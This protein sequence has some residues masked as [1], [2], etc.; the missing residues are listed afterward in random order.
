[1][2]IGGNGIVLKAANAK[3]SHVAIKV[4][5][6]KSKEIQLLKQV[7][8]PSIVQIIHAERDCKY[9]YLITELIQNNTPLCPDLFSLCDGNPL[10]IATVK[11]I[12]VQ[13]ALG[14]NALHQSGWAHCDLKLENVLVDNTMQVKICDFGHAVQS[15]GSRIVSKCGTIEITPP[16]LLDPLYRSIGY[17]LDV[18]AL[19]IAIYSMIEGAPGAD[20]ASPLPFMLDLLHYPCQFTQLISPYLKRLIHSMLMINPSARI[21][22][23]SILRHSWLNTPL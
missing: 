7:K 20:F 5:Y 3:G 21:T 1:V 16:E 19:G 22:V 12:T 13:I 11:H 18:W 17:P 6:T 2:G 14:L 23:S 15:N 8:H 10:D 4:I 9:E